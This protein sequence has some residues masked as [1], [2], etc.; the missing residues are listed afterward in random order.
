MTPNVIFPLRES[1]FGAK[2]VAENNPNKAQ[3]EICLA[4]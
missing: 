1:G 4:K 2:V 3:S